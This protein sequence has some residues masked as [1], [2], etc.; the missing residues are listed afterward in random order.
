MIAQHE[1][2]RSAGC[3]PV[4]RPS[5]SATDARA[6]PCARGT[7]KREILVPS[8][9]AACGDLHAGLSCNALRALFLRTRRFAS[10]FKLSHLRDQGFSV[11]LWLSSR[12][13]LGGVRFSPPGGLRKL[14][15]ARYNNP[16]GKSLPKSCSLRCSIRPL[17]VGSLGRRSW[18]QLEVPKHPR[19]PP[20]ARDEGLSAA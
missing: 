8:I 14:R 5:P 4:L 9:P 18:Y 19:V 20:D 1:A 17:R 13:Q 11:P 3:R 15:K 16:L 12:P 7:G 6:H 2:K 10:R